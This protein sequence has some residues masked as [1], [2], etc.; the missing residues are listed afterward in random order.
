MVTFLH[1]G[2]VLDLIGH[3]KKRTSREALKPKY[4]TL[5]ILITAYHFQGN[6]INA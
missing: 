4:R 6:N 3:Q 1:N 2:M 5:N